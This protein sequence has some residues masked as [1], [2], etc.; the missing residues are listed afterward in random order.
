MAID[1][2]LI[3]FHRYD[4]RGLVKLE[5]TY[6]AAITVFTII[7]AIVFLFIH[8]ADKGPMYGGVTVRWAAGGRGEDDVRDEPQLTPTP[9]LVRHQHQLGALPHHLLLRAD[10][11]WRHRPSST[12]RPQGANHG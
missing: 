5:K 2:Y 9:D 1:V 10:L 6:A 8:T 7:P 11:V 12:T 3:V 4:A